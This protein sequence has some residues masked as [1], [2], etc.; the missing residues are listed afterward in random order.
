MCIIFSFLNCKI[1]WFQNKVILIKTFFFES[2]S[3]FLYD[4]FQSGMWQVL[5]SW[6]FYLFS[7]KIGVSIQ[8]TDLL[9]AVWLTS[10]Y[11]PCC[12]Q[13]APWSQS[14]RKC[15]RLNWSILLDQMRWSRTTVFLLYTSRRFVTPIRQPG[16]DASNLFD[17]WPLWTPALFLIR[18][19]GSCMF[20]I[21]LQSV[22]V[23]P[24]QT[25]YA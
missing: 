24:L 25:I 17:R 9:S 5:L 1:P 3:T 16:V 8:S 13:Q 18:R 4:Y 11:L 12:C 2:C 20:S 21:Y 7:L 23:Q 14:P 19:H 15:H 22:K 10:F 6:N